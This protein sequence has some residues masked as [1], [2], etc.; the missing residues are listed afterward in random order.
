[1]VVIQKRNIAVVKS[2]FDPEWQCKIDEGLG[3]L[4]TARFGPMGATHILTFNDFGT[5]MN[6]WCLVDKECLSF[7]KYPK[8]SDKG[9]AYS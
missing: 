3:G 6:V 7:I 9:I 4:S 8:F 5:R 1:M 2:L